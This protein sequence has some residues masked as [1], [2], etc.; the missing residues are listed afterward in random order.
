MLGASFALPPFLDTKSLP[1]WI[2]PQTIEQ[3]EATCPSL[4]SFMTTTNR[5]I[6]GETAPSPIPW[7]ISIQFRGIDGAHYCGGSV[8]DSKTIVT[9][10]HCT[11]KSAE[12]YSKW[13]IRAGDTNKMEGQRIQIAQ[14]IIHPDW[15]PEMIRNDIAIIKLSEPL[16]LDETVQ[17]I[18]LPP[19]ELELEDGADCFA[20]GWGATQYSKIF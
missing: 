17:P 5:I 9:A 2:E 20:S 13:T 19:G 1:P 4:P 3:R 12:D 7:Q 10:A 11:D 14:V 18:C 8:L 15:D 16:T 6:D